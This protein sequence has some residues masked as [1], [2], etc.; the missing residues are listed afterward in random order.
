MRVGAWN[1]TSFQS[2]KKQEILQDLPDGNVKGAA[3]SETTTGRSSS[4]DTT[5]HTPAKV[6]QLEQKMRW[7]EWPFHLDS[8]SMPVTVRLFDR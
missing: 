4:L 2:T 6:R 8:F 7:S 1:F 3:G 5:T